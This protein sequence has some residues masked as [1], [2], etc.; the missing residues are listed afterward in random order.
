MLWSV[1]I[2]VA[3]LELQCGRYALWSAIGAEEAVRRYFP[4]LPMWDH[5]SPWRLGNGAGSLS[6][7]SQSRPIWGH[8]ERMSARVRDLMRPGTH[9]T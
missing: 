7:I 8:L 3:V 2:Y 6:V 4:G 1:K 9:G 5:T